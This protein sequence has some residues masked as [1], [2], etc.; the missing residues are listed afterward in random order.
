[1]GLGTRNFRPGYR[2]MSDAQPRVWISPQNALFL[3]NSRFLADDV[4]WADREAPELEGR[5]L[6]DLRAGATE[7]GLSVEVRDER[8]LAALLFFSPRHDTLLAGVEAHGGR[9]IYETPIAHPPLEKGPL[10]IA[11]Y[12]VDR[13]GSFRAIL[14]RG[15]VE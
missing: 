2:G 10:D 14:L 5:L 9:F 13:G 3:R 12:A 1:M 11:V 6:G 4:D 7:V 15:E 8:E